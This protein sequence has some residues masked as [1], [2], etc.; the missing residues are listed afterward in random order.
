LSITVL[1]G[2]ATAAAANPQT[3]AAESGGG[4]GAIGI[5]YL[6]ALFAAVLAAWRARRPPRSR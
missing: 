4:G 6:A 2:A 3:P 5:G 1:P